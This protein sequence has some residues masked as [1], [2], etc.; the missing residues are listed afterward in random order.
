MKIMLNLPIKRKWL[1][2]IERGEKREEYREFSNLQVVGAYNSAMRSPHA[3]GEWLLANPVAILRAGYRMGSRAVA[4]KI[5]GFSIRTGAR[6]P[7]WGETAGDGLLHIVIE[8]GEVVSSGTYADVKRACTKEKN[9]P[10]EQAEGARGEL[11]VAIDNQL[12]IY[13]QESGVL[14]R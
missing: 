2:M 4:V 1:D 10:E 11:R 6:H 7:E 8:L 5:D 3:H 13:T 14:I 9:A 12:E